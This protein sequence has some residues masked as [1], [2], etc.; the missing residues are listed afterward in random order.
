MRDRKSIIET[1]IYKT[2]E[3]VLRYGQGKY[4]KHQ[5]KVIVSFGL[6]SGALTCAMFNKGP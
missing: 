2:Q 4:T 5:N 6:Q 1:E 3:K